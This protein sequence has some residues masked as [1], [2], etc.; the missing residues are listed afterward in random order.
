M[1]SSS[2]YLNHAGTSW[3]KPAGV[4]DAVNEAMHSN[5]MQWPERFDAAH[6]SV[7]GYFGVDCLEQILLTPGCTSALAVAVADV[8]LQKHERV[9]TSQ[10]EH[11]ALHR[12]LQKLAAGGVLVESIPPEKSSSGGIV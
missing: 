1:D 3:P 6:Q 12:P 5:P 4:V 11:H 7:A 8:S 10:W 2:C 9:L